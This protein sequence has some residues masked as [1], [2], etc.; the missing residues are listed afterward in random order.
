MS[1]P[2]AKTLYA[3]YDLKHSPITFDSLLFVAMAEVFRRGLGFDNLQFIIT[4]AEDG[5]FRRRTEKDHVLSDEDK[6]WRVRHVTAPSCLAVE[7]CAGVWVC[8]DR[9][10]ARRFFETLD[11]RQVFPHGYTLDQPRFAFMISQLV[12]LHARGHDVQV[13]RSRPEARNVVQGWM[14]TNKITRPIVVLSTRTSTAHQW[15]NSDPMAWNNFANYADEIGYDVVAIPDTALALAGQIPRLGN[16]SKT[17]F[18]G[19][20]D[21]DLRAAL[22]DMAAVTLSTHGGPAMFNPF[23]HNRFGMFQGEAFDLGPEEFYRLWRVKW[24]D[25]FPWASAGQ[26][27]AYVADTEDNIKALFHEVMEAEISDAQSG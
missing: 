11:P 5:G 26:R 8:E 20:L 13:L 12:D 7:S 21:F 2:D 27:V 18:Q 22:Y 4:T 19:A 24:G 10:A 25:Q 14:A 23:S 16:R 15:K 3:F 9:A 17:F 6:R 1:Q